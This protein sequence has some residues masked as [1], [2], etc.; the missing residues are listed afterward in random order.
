MSHSLIT[1]QGT[2]SKAFSIVPYLTR[3][4]VIR[5][6]EAIT[7]RHQTETGC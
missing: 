6:A 7:G 4:E 1:R 5:M 3:E 2:L